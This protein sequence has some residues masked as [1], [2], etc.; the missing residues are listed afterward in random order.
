MIIWSFYF[1]C[2]IS[3]K[4]FHS[5]CAR[6][7]VLFYLCI[8]ESFYTPIIT[9]LFYSSDYLIL[10][11]HWSDKYKVI[12][13]VCLSL[14]YSISWLSYSIW[15]F[16]DKF[17]HLFRYNCLTLW[18]LFYFNKFIYFWTKYSFHTVVKLL[19]MLFLIILQ[20][21]YIQSNYE[22]NVIFVS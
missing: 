9:E 17:L 10:F 11:F 2:L 14:F 5:H 21:N 4:I 8:Y 19:W 13:F 12:L 20:K 6:I 7:T 22:T 3:I 15:L 16:N 1:T 18:F